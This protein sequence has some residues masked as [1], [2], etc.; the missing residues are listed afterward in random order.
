MRA[1]VQR[2]RTAAVRVADDE[3]G[4]IGPGLLVYLGVADDD[5][6]RDAAW[7]ARKLAELRLFEGDDG[8]LDRS[9]ANRR[10]A[11]EP[12]SALVIS[13]FT[14]LAD[15]G[16]GRRP[17]FVRAAPPERAVPLYEAVLRSLREGGIEVATGRFGARML[18]E[19]ENAGPVTLWL[20]SARSVRRPDG[21]A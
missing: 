15:I 17:S 3:V 1:V 11:G 12:A 19:S 6:E 9:L 8:R 16:K 13:Q 14:L 20:D 7:V 10:R 4:R 5:T 18:V 2:V 21:K